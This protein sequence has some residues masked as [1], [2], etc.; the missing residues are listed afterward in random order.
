MDSRR[1][2]EVCVRAAGLAG[3]DVVGRAAGRCR[4]AA[5]QVAGAEAG[6]F[7]L[8]TEEVRMVEQVEE[9]HAELQVEALVEGPVL[10]QLHIDV[11]G[12]RSE[13]ITA[14]RVR[15]ER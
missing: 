5:D 14:R 2:P 6:S 13:A 4:A 7:E 9:V 1:L 3:D 10:C 11:A 12:G 15:T 8:V